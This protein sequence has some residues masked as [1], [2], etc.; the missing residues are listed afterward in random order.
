MV[1]AAL[2]LQGALSQGVHRCFNLTLWLES[3]A[4][5]LRMDQS[6]QLRNP[7]DSMNNNR[8][9]SKSQVIVVHMKGGEGVHNNWTEEENLR[10]ASS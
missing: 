6:Q 9:T 1:H 8:F 7:E 5:H 3:S 4:T 10:L 2:K